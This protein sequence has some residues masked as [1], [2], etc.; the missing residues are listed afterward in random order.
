[1][2]SG[3]RD[4]SEEGLV[5]AASFA[6]AV[7]VDDSRLGQIVG[8]HFQLDSVAEKNL[9][10]MAAEPA[11]YVGEYGMSVFQLNREGRTGEDLLD[12]PVELQGSFLGGIVSDAFARLA[13]RG[14]AS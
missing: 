8:R 9:D 4:A 11:G 14:S 3:R 1:R 6:G 7:A 5:R 12:R 10:A 2:H 13:R